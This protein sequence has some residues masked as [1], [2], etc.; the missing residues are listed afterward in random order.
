METEL[1][2]GALVASSSTVSATALGMAGASGSKGVRSRTAGAATMGQGG[3][4][5]GIGAGAGGEAGEGGKHHSGLLSEADD[6][7]ARSRGAKVGRVDA[8]VVGNSHSFSRGYLHSRRFFFPPCVLWGRTFVR[9]R[10][11]VGGSSLKSCRRRGVNVL[12]DRSS[13]SRPIGTKRSAR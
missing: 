2:T 9:L 11:Q 1:H 6:S 5:E 3:R 8:V 4:G 13:L 10:P 7:R 12:S